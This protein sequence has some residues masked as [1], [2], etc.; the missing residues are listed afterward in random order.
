LFRTGAPEFRPAHRLFLPRTPGQEEENVTTSRRLTIAAVLAA[1]GCACLT[2]PPCRAAGGQPLNLADLV[3]Q[4]TDIVRGTV[5]SV[6]EGVDG[7]QMPYTE[8][9]L[10]VSETIRGAA[11]AALVFRQFGVQAPKPG[12]NQRPRVGVIDGMPR[13]AAG[14][15]V[16]LFLGPVSQIGFRTTV[17]MGQGHFT[18]RDG[19]FENDSANAG[20]FRNVSFGKNSLTDR[21][22]AL[23][24][25]DRGGVGADALLGLVRR[26]V[27][28][29]WW[30]LPAVPTP[31]PSASAP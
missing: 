9:K 22:K 26:S 7:K 31:R 29:N 6:T 21:E 20:L 30:N 8:V 25:T 18:L 14:D 1:L 27:R 10:K 13:Y 16:L 4:S 2:A 24:A 19:N 23:V 17:G 11:G 12:T 5:S 15:Q 28:E 3:R